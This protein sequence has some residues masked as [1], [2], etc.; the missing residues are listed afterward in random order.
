MKKI[1]LLFVLCAAATAFCALAFVNNVAAVAQWWSAFLAAGGDSSSVAAKMPGIIP[2]L[3]W[4]AVDYS[5]VTTFIPMLGFLCM[6]VS[7]ARMAAGRR[8]R[9]P[10]CRYRGTYPTTRAGK[11]PTRCAAW[12]GLLDSGA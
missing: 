2:W 5:A 1:L 10:R 6:T 3:S 7:L 4:S 11:C 8:M 12:R 9:A